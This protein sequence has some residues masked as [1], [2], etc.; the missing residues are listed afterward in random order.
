MYMMAVDRMPLSLAVILMNLSPFWCSILGN[1]FHN[2]PIYRIEFVAMAVCF[3]CVIG[4][5]LSKPTEEKDLKKEHNIVVGVILAIAVSCTMAS[6]SVVS[7][8][9][10]DV[11]YE[12]TFFL[13]SILIG[14]VPLFCQAVY[15]FI[16]GSPFY[17]YSYEGFF[18]ILLGGLIDNT[19]CITG[20]VAF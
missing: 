4:V 5:T 6:A 18:W 10:K 17:N 14:I 20:M 19:S 12:V 7:R 13:H 16:S 3:L 15:A 9:L 2:E 1:Y 11:P 8:A